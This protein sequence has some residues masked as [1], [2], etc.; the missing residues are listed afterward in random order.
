MKERTL[1]VLRLER[2]FLQQLRGT[3]HSTGILQC[4]EISRYLSIPELYFSDVVI[5]IYIILFMCTC[6]FCFLFFVSFSS[7]FTP[8]SLLIFHYCPIFYY[9]FISVN[10]N[11]LCL[12]ISE[13]NYTVQIKIL[14]DQHGM[15][16][17]N[18]FPPNS[19]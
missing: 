14:W 19:C 8:L 11:F 6:V 4:W 17:W 9:I 10:L 3:Y 12:F 13:F 16:V 2:G 5:I 18:F 15:K 7:K 1:N